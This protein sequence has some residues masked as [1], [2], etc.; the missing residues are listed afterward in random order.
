MN[1]VCHLTCMTIHSSPSSFTHETRST[2]YV[3]RVVFTVSRA[4]HVAVF[5]VE[6]SIITS[7]IKSDKLHNIVKKFIEY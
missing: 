1:N 4:W 2:L 3:T 6:T 5:T 7:C